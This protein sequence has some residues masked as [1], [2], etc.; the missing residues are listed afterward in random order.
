MG[1]NKLVNLP[2][3]FLLFVCIAT[4]AWAQEK[5]QKPFIYGQFGAEGGNYGGFTLAGTYVFPSKYV[6]QVGYKA[7]VSNAEERPSDYQAGTF[8]FFTLGLSSAKDT[9][10]I[11]H[12]SF[13]KILELKNHPKTRFNILGGVGV[14]FSNFATNFEDTGSAFGLVS[15]YT[16]D[17]ENSTAV[18]FIIQ[19][20]VEF[21]LSQHHGIAVGPVIKL[22]ERE[23]LF[24]LSVNYIVGRLRNTIET[25]Q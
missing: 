24:G 8:D 10:T 4:S 14:S 25:S 21:C 13:G 2:V 11:V 3:Y 16:F 9:Y 17:T 6:L 23:N 22:S 15:N 12:A 1:V 19:P 20:K 18:F 5:E 7:L